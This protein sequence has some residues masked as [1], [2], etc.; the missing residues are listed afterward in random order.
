MIDPAE[1][2]TA[3]LALSAEMPE[4]FELVGVTFYGPEGHRDWEAVSRSGDEEN[5]MTC[6]GWGDTP[7]EALKELRTHLRSEHPDEFGAIGEG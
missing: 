5:P 3:F 4:P 2:R 7:Y 1:L 6:E